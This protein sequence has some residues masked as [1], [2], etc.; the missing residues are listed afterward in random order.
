MK[1][2]AKA[3]H[4]RLWLWLA[5]NPGRHKSD[6]PEWQANGGRIP[7]VYQNCFACAVALRNKI[8]NTGTCGSKKCPLFQCQ[9]NLGFWL[10]ALAEGDA[11]QIS[12]YATELAE[13]PWKGPTY[14]NFD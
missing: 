2:N 4:R 3:A 11:A 1:I 13:Q 10:H 9:P 6:W 7:R 12:K 5:D 14:L 8:K